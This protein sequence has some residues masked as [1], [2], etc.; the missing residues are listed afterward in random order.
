MT[1]ALL[2]TAFVISTCGLVYELIAGTVAS[3]LLGDSVTQFSTVIGVYL[4]SM[5]IGSFLSRYIKNQNLNLVFVNV[6]IIVGLVGGFSACLLFMLFEHVENFRILLYGLVTII[7]ILIGLEIPLLMRILK[8]RLQFEDLV[9][10]IFTFDYVGALLAS[11]LFPLVLV[12]QLGL[13]RSSF[14]FGMFNVGTAIWTL[15]L[16]RKEIAWFK[17]MQSLAVVSIIV[18]LGGFAYSDKLLALAESASFQDPVIFSTS[19]PYQ[20]IIITGGGKET[21]LFLN[22]NLQFCSRDEYRYHE[23]LVHPALASLP[24]CLNAQANLSVLV[25]GGGDGMAV[26]EVLK[27]KGVKSVTLVDLDEEMTK[28]FKEQGLLTRLNDNALNS[29]KLKII[30]GDAF[31]W[32]RGTKQKFD[33]VVVDFPDPSNFSLGKLYSDT[34]YRSLKNAL[35]PDGLVVIQSTS[36]YYAKNSYWC[37]VKTLE[38]VGFRTTP[39]HAYVPSFG[40]WGYVIASLAPF[41]MQHEYPQ[42]LRFLSQS[43]AEQ[44]Q[45]FPQDMQATVTC[46]NKLNNQGLVH[47]FESEW[48]DYVGTH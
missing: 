11:I 4:F 8:D 26:R 1:Y 25:L 48:G 46:V 7:G 28:L 37:V 19:T 15:Y 9:S 2:L 23:A 17:A 3:Y 34:F 18:L 10:K 35:K 22:G 5:G 30:N 47:L 44:M 36:P 42:G 20:R 14:L 16:F 39:Y 40:D 41:K 45:F 21:K 13:L 31:N 12:P 24:G 29:N 32:L 33:C 38:S 6:E 43:T 27:Y